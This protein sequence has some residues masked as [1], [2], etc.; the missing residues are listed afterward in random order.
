MVKLSKIP[1]ET[2]K[3]CKLPTAMNPL[4]NVFTW[5]RRFRDD[6]EGVVDDPA[7]G[8][9]SSSR[10][11]NNIENVRQKL[12]DNRAQSMRMNVIDLDINKVSEIVVQDL[13]KGLCVIWTT[14]THCRTK[15][16]HKPIVVQQFLAQKELTV[17]TQTI[18]AR[19]G[20]DRLFFIRQIKIP[21]EGSTI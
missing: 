20:T 3:G 21:A 12:N 6:R 16:S 1:L 10:T 5:H 15:G 17:K 8:H 14:C 4:A 9:P 13:K 19:F 18:F 7:E 11:N 2:V